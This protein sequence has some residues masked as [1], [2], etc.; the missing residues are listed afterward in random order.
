MYD[1][2]PRN[3]DE[4]ITH[5]GCNLATYR[6]RV[7]QWQ[8]QEARGEGGDEPV[9]RILTDADAIA[10]GYPNLLSYKYAVRNYAH[11]NMRAADRHARAETNKMRY[12]AVEPSAA[13]RKV[14]Q[15]S[16]F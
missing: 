16:G 12:R 7:R 15:P 8:A 5:Y 1:F 13:L 11:A 4:A 10:A 3:D 14:P 9:R 2:V 6:M